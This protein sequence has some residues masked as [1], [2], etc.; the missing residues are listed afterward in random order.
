MNV[1]TK[2]RCTCTVLVP[3]IMTAHLTAQIPKSFR[4][5]VWFHKS[6]L[7][8]KKRVHPQLRATTLNR[9]V[10]KPGFADND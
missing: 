8:F 1:S 6:L 7:K 2:R 9:H 3:L 10:R 5:L 4:H